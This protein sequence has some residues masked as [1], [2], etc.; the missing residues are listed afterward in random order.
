MGSSAR[1]GVLPLGTAN[2]LAAGARQVRARRVDAVRDAPIPARSN[3]DAAG[4]DPA[5][6]A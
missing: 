6:Y 4:I 2:V 3:T 1:L 5:L